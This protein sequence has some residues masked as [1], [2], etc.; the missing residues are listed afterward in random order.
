[1]DISAEFRG[2]QLGD[3]RL[4]K[5][6]LGL[7]RKLESKH[8]GALSYTCGDWKNAKAAYRFFDNARFSESDII[9]PHCSQTATRVRAAKK[10]EPVLVIHDST[11]FSFTHHTKTEGLGYIT[12]SFEGTEEDSSYAKG[13]DLHTSLAMTNG[14]IPLG[15]LFS[16]Q[17]S[18]DIRNLHRVHRSGKNPTRIPI[19]EKESYKWIEGI[20]QACDACGS[21]NLV[22]ICDRD[23]DIYELFETCE[24]RETTF[25]VRAVHSRGT[26]VPGQK[27]FAKLARTAPC[28]SYQLEIQ[29]SKK[30]VARTAEIEVKFYRVE[31][32]P[33]I[34]KRKIC[35]PVAIYVVSAI[36]KASSEVPA[37]QR[38][39]WRLLTNSPV[40]SFDDALQII[41]WYQARWN[42]EVFF[43]TMKSGF[44]LEKARLRHASRLKK[45][46]ALVSVVAWRVF[47]LTRIARIAP[48]APAALCFT[49]KELRALVKIERSAERKTDIESATVIHYTIALAKLGGYLGRKNDPPPGDLVIWRGWQRL[50]DVMMIA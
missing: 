36:E 8:G 13:F 41:A 46:V 22:H 26:A 42:I 30:Q 39:N 19:R 14:G 27:S 18:R 2:A 43:K 29:S 49:P 28:G 12:G 50:S 10:G 25:V 37:T 23:G 15:L 7:A 45:L 20:Q 6:L 24:T 33:P 40:G 32:I 5:R 48:E 35:E 44:G 3:S 31:L 16:K 38:V 9:A 1:M 4:N 17:W 21:E 47:W 34:A 11:S